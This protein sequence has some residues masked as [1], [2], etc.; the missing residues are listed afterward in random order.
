MKLI[1]AFILFS[2]FSLVQGHERTIRIGILAKRGVDKTL[3]RWKPMAD[4][5]N[6]KMENHSVS[7]IALPFEDVE[8]AVENHTVDF[9]LTN[10][11]NYV[12]LEMKYGV[13]PVATMNN[14]ATGGIV[15]NNF[16]GVIFTRSDRA[17]INS[18]ADIKGRRF[19]AVDELSFGGWQM[20]WRE[21]KK[22]GIEPHKEFSPLLFT[23]T[24]DGVV[25]VVLDGEVDAG[26]V[27]TDTLEKMAKEGNL[28]LKKIKV[29][30]PKK[31]PNFP[32]L[33]STPL[34]PEWP[35]AKLSETPMDMAKELTKVLF[36][37]KPDCGCSVQSGI[38]GWT[39]PADYKPVHDALKELNIGP[40][41]DKYF[42]IKDVIQKYWEYI[43]IVVLLF[44][45]IIISSLYLYRVQKITNKVNKKIR[46][47]N[48][49]LEVKVKERTKELNEINKTLEERVAHE[50]RESRKK[51]EAILVQSRYAAMGEMVGMLAHQWRQPI[52]V[53]QM[54]ANN[55]M[56]DLELGEEEPEEFKKELSIISDETQKLS[57]IIDAFSSKF[58]D[59]SNEE[60]IKVQNIMDEVLDFVHNSF[61]SHNITAKKQYKNRSE[62]TLVKRQL[63]QVYLNIL[64]N[65]KEILLERAVKEPKI[66]VVVEESE[67]EVI[68]HICDN[69]GGIDDC[70]LHQIFEP[71]F[72]TKDEK[73]GCGLGLY[74]SKTIVEKQ[75]HGTIK[76]TKN[77]SYTC[78]TI[79]LEKNKQTT[80]V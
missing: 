31:Y 41:K 29:I 36:D 78:F 72:S 47:I 52:A 5:L 66:V 37:M 15:V 32:F 27:R 46:D 20:A 71:Y 67:T 14:R 58:K 45:V 21:F 73:N 77:G 9:I 23:Q 17:D 30:D 68:T 55:M 24:H 62:L 26:S 43:V 44:F 39:I 64:T 57:Q 4:F 2:F 61:E 65:A 11:S 1:L 54:S 69:G 13:S 38:G 49:T 19:A 51:D 48:R 8:K 7:I 28:D 63:F 34:Y 76:L 50:V 42:S 3:E 16:G 35:L 40:Y 70:H 10:S 18:L 12:T 6:E 22:A 25:K 74:I 59:D 60:I 79:S 33:I 53:I 80:S 75:L 56:L